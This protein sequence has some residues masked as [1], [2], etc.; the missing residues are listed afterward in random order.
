L[1]DCGQPFLNEYSEIQ[2][3]LWAI[4]DFL[5][6]ISADGI[7]Q[8]GHAGDASQLF[9]PP[10]KFVGQSCDSVLPPDLSVLT[11]EKIRKTIETKEMQTYEY[12]L[13]MGEEEKKFETRMV[14]LNPGAVLAIVRDITEQ[15][16]LKIA[17]Q[18]QEDQLNLAVSTAQIGYWRWHVATGEVSWYWDHGNLFGIRKADFGGT[19]D[20]VQEMVHPDDREKGIAN[21]QKTLDTGQPFENT[22]RVVHP[23][24]SV[25]WLNSF[26]DLHRDEQGR[27][28]HIFGITRDITQFKAA[29]EKLYAYSKQLEESNIALNRLLDNQ[30]EHKNRLAETLLR[31]FEQLVFPYLEQLANCRNLDTVSSLSKILVDN[32]KK[33][34]EDLGRSSPLVAR[35]FTLMEIQV[36]D[37]IKQG[38]TAKEIAGILH[39][40]PRTVFF[41]RNNIRKKLDI[42]HTRTNLRA[43]LTTLV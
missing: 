12:A 20:H 29:E 37:L 35:H 21:L 26:G 13:R 33:C 1:K 23:D 32:T 36:A 10:E 7:F 9:L 16:R 19:I 17:I 34:L 42:Q 18:E 8:F 28:E 25:H 14:Y 38:R 40:S 31:D 11:R 41:Y 3:L 39:M 15:H 27:P 30:K 22:Y 43:M 6:Q 4:P 5:F 24:G 2:A